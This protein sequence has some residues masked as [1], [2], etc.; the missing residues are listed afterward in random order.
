VIRSELSG[1]GEKTMSSKLEKIAKSLL[2]CALALAA[3]APAAPQELAPVRIN[4][5]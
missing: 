1:I 3:A 2:F 5:W 4:A